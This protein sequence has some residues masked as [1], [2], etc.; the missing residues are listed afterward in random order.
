MSELQDDGER[1]LATDVTRSVIVRAPAGSGKTTLLVQR[2]LALLAT[3]REPEEILAITFTIKAAG[4]M[5]LRVLEALRRREPQARAALARDAERG[6]NLLEAP[7]R[8]KIQTIDS[9][10][11]T[12][13]RQLP[14]RSGFNPQA[15][16]TEAAQEL[17]ASAAERVLLRL[18]QADPFAEEI[19]DFLEQCG[20]DQARARRLLAEMLEHRDQ[21]VRVASEV[22]RASRSGSAE[23]RAVL[24][25]GIDALSQQLIHAFQGHL[26][27]AERASLERLAEV[28][29]DNL[30]LELESSR[31]RYRLA[32]ELLTRG[33]G[34]WRR[35]ITKREGFPADQR[36]AKGE[37]MA[38]IDTLAARDLELE[39]ANLR[40]LPRPPGQ[41]ALRSLVNVCVCLVLAVLELK[42][43]FGRQETSDFTELLINAQAA[44]GE[45]LSPSE[46]A[47][48]LD[49]RLNH[50][51]VDEFQ[52]TSVSQFRLFEQLL[53]GFM[54]GEGTS[55]FA[56]GD[57]MQSIYRFR[58]ADVGLFYRAAE[59]GVASL[60]LASTVL[61]SNFRSAPALGSWCNVT[62]G[63]VLGSEQDPV[64]GAVPFSPSVASRDE[65]G[66]VS[67]HLYADADAQCLGI[68][69]H[70][71]RLL[72][73]P[74][75]A[76]IALLVRSRQQLLPL[77]PELRRRGI[78]WQAND[79]DPLIGKPVVRDLLNISR[80]LENPH[81][82][83]A[84]FAVLRAPW[85]GL[86]LEDLQQFAD[87]ARIEDALTERRERLSSDGQ[88]RIDRLRTAL[89]EARASRDEV[90][91][92]SLLETFWLKVGGADAYADPA[93][94]THAERLLT[95]LDE[96]GL[97]LD[98][99]ALEAAAVNLFASDVTR[100]RLQIMTIHKAK[101]LEFDHVLLP[102]LEKTTRADEAGLLLWRALPEGLLLG[103]RDDD[104]AYE[105]LKREDKAREQHERERLLYVACTRARS[106][107]KLFAAPGE[108]PPSRSLLALLWPDIEAAVTSGELPVQHSARPPEQGELFVEPA[109]EERALVRLPGD[110]R[111]E[112]P[113]TGWQAP[114]ALAAPAPAAD[115]SIQSDVK[116]ALG[117]IL[118][119]EL[120]RLADRDP[121]PSALPATERRASWQRQAQAL[122]VGP[123]DID[124]LLADLGRQLDNV[125]EDEQG[126]WLLSPQRDGAAELKLTVVQ[127]GE[128]THL[129]IDRTFSCAGERW[130]IDYKTGTPAPGISE[131]AF[132]S[133]EVAR[134]RPQLDGYARAAAALFDEPVR[135]AIFFTAL[136]RLQE[137]VG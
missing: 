79:I 19:A 11:M 6:W 109:A 46:L 20:N 1:Q 128:P 127:A 133:A 113:A 82:R 121:L 75:D 49:H 131:D 118:H 123:A 59:Q 87:A 105:W 69:E 114:P 22:V 57:P 7:A 104:G 30:E 48:A 44:L 33:D 83:L 54:P 28:A 72:E 108:R 67:W 14:I 106:T 62:F 90:P 65:A 10:A 36:A 81:D 3:A 18:Y 27:A 71:R 78:S 43:L 102:F 9:F 100:A 45:S 96:A 94:L 137:V 136:P 26:S 88:R 68:A 74:G 15:G 35:Q 73:E 130:V 125:L 85:C 93:T 95:L 42:T 110:Y 134:Y 112:P 116:V 21:W 120:E 32:G 64:L 47:L 101:G 115:D 61:S 38:L 126:R 24:E 12:L 92:R 31:D 86:R 107:L 51:L 2:Y 16:I 29:A 99:G 5:R 39:A 77:L 76:S 25:T 70:L 56:V 17:Y 103:T 66:G 124:G 58:D 4:E 60:P 53:A 52:D 37:L 63:R 41:A 34:R 135:A 84:W 111:W 23:V 98:S 8:L 117:I 122:G 119:R 50:V 40:Y 13:A 129:I 97:S 91:P 80:I 132:V 55:F 89:D